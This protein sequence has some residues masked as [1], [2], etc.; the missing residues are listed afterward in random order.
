MTVHTSLIVI[1]TMKKICVHCGSEFDA[2]NMRVTLCPSCVHAMD[3]CPICG[4][5]KSIWK[6]TCSRSC[7]AKLQCMNSNPLNTEKAIEKRKQ[8]CM[9][10]YGSTVALWGSNKEKTLQRNRE[11]FGGNSPFSNVAVQ[12]KAQDTCVARYGVPFGGGSAEALMKKRKTMLDKYGV[13]HNKHIHMRNVDDLTR[14]FI[15]ARFVDERKHVDF[16]SLIDYFGFSGSGHARRALARL[17]VDWVRNYQ[18]QQ[19]E[20]ED[21]VR[22][23]CGCDIDVNTRTFI[24]P[25]ELDILIPDKFVAFEYNGTYWHSDEALLKKKGMTSDEFNSIKLARCA[26]KG[27]HLYFITEDAWVNRRDETERFVI[28]VLK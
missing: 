25:L 10:K 21:F 7:A 14:E 9:D 27:V 17:G 13:E 28:E 4:K 16:D 26:E 23:V 22:S 19:R 12:K 8:T 5:E 24:P 11:R 1:L 3:T 2:R 18:A 15:E 20:L 6:G